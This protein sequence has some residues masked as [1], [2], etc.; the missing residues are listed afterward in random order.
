MSF[1]HSG[2]SLVNQWNQ[3][4]DYVRPKVLFISPNRISMKRMCSGERSGKISAEQWCVTVHKTL[5]SGTHAG[6]NTQPSHLYLTLL[7]AD[8]V[9]CGIAMCGKKNKQLI[10]FLDCEKYS[11]YRHTSY[12]LTMNR[13]LLIVTIHCDGLRW[14]P[15]ALVPML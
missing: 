3:R 15:G 1:A 10:S 4:L 6:L 11:C 9:S 7:S 5:R 13:Q 8:G 12:T 14:R 2:P